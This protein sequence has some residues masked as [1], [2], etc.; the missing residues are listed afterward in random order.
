MSAMGSRERQ[1]IIGAGRGRAMTDAILRELHD[2]RLNRNL[3][4]RTVADTIGISPAEYSRMER[5]LT[6][7]ITIERAAVLLA[8]VGLDLSVRVYPGGQP[9]RDIA[10]TALL[11][12]LRAL[13]HPSIRVLTE[14][15]F[16]DRADQRAWDLVAA[17]PSWRHA[18]EA[19]TRPRDR[20]ALERRI[21]LK[22]RDGMIDGVSLLLTDSRHNREFVR[23]NA[24]ALKDR[25]PVP[26]RTV[27]A[28]LRAGTDPGQGGIV[29]L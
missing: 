20:Q 8:A 21:A 15:A 27:L 24:S 19:E 23:A 10:H 7:S 2:G 29:L 26:G 14:V 13:V 6:R 22:V 18:F 12:R 4:G 17:G 25:F 16:P 28:R 1:A 5:G 9:I 11:G 3:S